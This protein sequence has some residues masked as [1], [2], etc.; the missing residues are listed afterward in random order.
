M[1]KTISF[2]LLSIFLFNTAGYL[3]AFRIARVE[4]K[5]E[6]QELIRQGVAEEALKSFTI[7]KYGNKTSLKVEGDELCSEG[8]YFDIVSV[9]ETPGTITYYCVDDRM[10]SSLMSVLELHI[11]TYVSSQPLK[12]DPAKKISEHAA[13]LYIHTEE[14]SFC[15][16]PESLVE[17]GSLVS[18][19]H[20][21]YTFIT[22]PP[23]ERF[24]AICFLT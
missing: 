17:P 11:G 1:K 8:K 13:K 3:V 10:E 21:A 9:S 19:T 7:K 23:P 2:F 16:L 22:A 24:N 5:K 20:S 12:E 14:P 4:I 6:M 15:F 18:I